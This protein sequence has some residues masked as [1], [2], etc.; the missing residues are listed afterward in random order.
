MTVHT[1]S[2]VM[3]PGF[4]PRSAHGTAYLNEKEGHTDDQGYPFVEAFIEGIFRILYS[5]YLLT[6]V[7]IVPRW[8]VVQADYS[9]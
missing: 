8:Y 6:V 9:T 5:L 4:Q 1:S 2:F 3:S 7:D